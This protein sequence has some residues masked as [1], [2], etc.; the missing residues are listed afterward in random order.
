MNKRTDFTAACGL[1]LSEGQFAPLEAYVDLIWQ[2]KD[3][4]NL[5]AAQTK[6]EMWDRHICDALALAG[7]LNK[8]A[9][10]NP[11]TLADFGAGAGYIG[12]GV[13]MALPKANVTLIDSLQKR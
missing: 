13:A 12:F 1:N 9:A 4:L 11:F 3:D 7:V 8:L 2:K 10:D 6:Q 5:T